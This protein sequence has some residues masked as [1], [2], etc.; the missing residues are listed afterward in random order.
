[1][2]DPTV[3]VVVPAYNAEAF[4]GRALDS[5]L[6]QT[7]EDWEIVLVNDGSTDETEAVVNRYAQRIG[8]R[9]RCF[10]Q[11]NAGCGAA[12]NRGIDAARGRFVAF[13][14]ADDE[15]LPRKLERQL[16]L[17]Q[18]RPDLGLVFSD[19]ALVDLDGKRHESAFDRDPTV[20]RRV[21]IE[22][23]GD[24]Y[25]VCSP[26][27]FDYL[28]RRYFI[29]TI[30]GMVRRDVLGRSIRWPPDPSYSAEWLFFLRVARISRVGFVDEP[31][32]LHHFIARSATRTDPRRNTVR[33]RN[34]L[35]EM[36]RALPNL[37]RRQRRILRDHRARTCRQLGFDEY[38]AGHFSRATRH[39]AESF[40]HRP[41]LGTLRDVADAGLHSVW[42]KA[43]A[44]ERNEPWSP[45][46]G[47]AEAVAR[48]PMD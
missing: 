2:S 16:G 47:T 14:D 30:V 1:V 6:A 23:L 33:L 32:S 37:N 31:L 18:A 24:T 15:F 27:F 13:L 26:D 22:C 48:Q 41:A 11:P 12:R 42:P 40:L 44:D 4:L 8:R 17:F 36:K 28:L 19:M 45:V 43:K 34:L 5:I 35:R 29:P 20:V 25:R 21:P 38:W 39:L 7:F 3:S 9:L 46:G 10:C